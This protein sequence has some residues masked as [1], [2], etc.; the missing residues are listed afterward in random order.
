[1]TPAHSRWL[2]EGYSRSWLRPSS[3]RSPVRRQ[4]LRPPLPINA[5]E[6]R[7]QQYAATSVSARRRGIFHLRAAPMSSRA[8]PPQHCY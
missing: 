7:R 1:L 4:T 3:R 2:C 8:S 6:S 5:S